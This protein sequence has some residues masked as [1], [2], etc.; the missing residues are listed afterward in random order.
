VLALGNIAHQAVLL[1]LGVRKTQY[2]FHH[3]A[4][5]ELPNGLALYDSYHCSRYNTQTRRL[6]EKMFSQVFSDIVKHLTFPGRRRL[7]S[8][9]KA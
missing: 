5:H 2:P 6:T 3:G 8:F 1:A 4:R 9:T 7:P